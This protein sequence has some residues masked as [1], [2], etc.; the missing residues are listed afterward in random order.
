MLAAPA[1]LYLILR[2]RGMAPPQLPDPSMHTTFIIAPHDIFTR[3]AA[4]FTPTAR[5]REA[6]RVGFLVP[7]R[8]TYLLFGAVPG[9]FVFRYVLVLVAIVPAYLL[10]RRLYG[11]WA[12]VL[13]IVVIISSPVLITAWGTDYPDSAAAS[14][15]T[16]SLAALALS[17]LPGRFRHGWVLL[18][19]VLFTLAV[20]SHA[21][22]V[23]LVAAA[24]IVLL[25]IRVAD[26][27]PHLLSDLG[28]LAGVTILVSGLLAVCS[29]LLLGQFDFVT[30]TIVAE[31]FLSTP[32]QERLW[33]SASW[34]W[35]PYDAYL[36]V[37]PAILAAFLV[38]F[39]RRPRPVPMATLFLGLCGALQL[40]LFTYLQF[41]ANV[42][43]LEMH[44]L[45]SPLW[46]STNLLLALVLAETAR[47]MVVSRSVG[48]LPALLALAVGVVYGSLHLR[49]PAMTWSPWGAG[50]VLVIAGAALAGRLA[51]ATHPGSAGQLRYR[52][53]APLS[54]LAI[55]ATALIVLIGATLV[56]TVAPRRAHAALANTVYD[57]PPAYATALGGNGGY[58]LDQ[59]L[60]TS[61]VPMFVGPPAYA[62]EQLLTWWPPA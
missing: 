23:P 8:L 24:L 31:R 7:A 56:L 3:Y 26:D 43:T 17:C 10:A 28:S 52:S 55:S 29:K 60:V 51:S 14:Y 53:H 38:V 59:Y 16:G 33:H 20:W 25:V 21:V 49:I 12:G 46:S 47:P 2:I 36:L 6:A 5:L 44:F 57:P 9:F 62:G 48:W 34:A 42:Q 45:S 58:Y 54:G 15:L 41:F 40:A 35:A 18:G 32:A 1:L 4:V 30:P 61:R 27:R 19:G 13:A 50:L 37:P 11:R 22:S 39:F